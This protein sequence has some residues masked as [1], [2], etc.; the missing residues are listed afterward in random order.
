MRPLMI[1]GIVL[2]VLGVACLMFNGVTYFTTERVGQAGPFAV[3]VSR[4]HTILINPI[5]GLACLAAGVVCMV[6]GSSRRALT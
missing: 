1:L 2:V 4:P 3:D 6:A 5:A